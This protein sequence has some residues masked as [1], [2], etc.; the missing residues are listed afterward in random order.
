MTR[1]VHDIPPA[2]RRVRWR[3]VL[4]HRWPVAFLGFVLAVYGGF[5]TLMLCLAAG[6]KPADDG[7]LDRECVVTRGI[8]NRVELVHGRPPRVHYDFPVVNRAGHR[9]RQSGCSFLPG[10]ETLEKGDRIPIEHA[11]GQPSLSRAMGGRIVIMPPLL[12]Y[13]FYGIFLPGILLLILWFATVL[14][15]RRLMIHGDVAVGEVLSFRILR[16]VLPLMYVV[17]YR[18]RDHHARTHTTC[19]WVRAR[20]AL[21]DRL[22]ANPQQIGVIHDRR[23]RGVS[24]LVMASDFAAVNTGAAVAQGAA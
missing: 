12:S 14:R 4:W 8:V 15:L 3:A 21:G 22:R 17:E 10:G 1:E 6:G 19:H 5:I 18:F 23:G 13:F 2:P 7:R 16:F 11:R 9:F 20:S 24:R